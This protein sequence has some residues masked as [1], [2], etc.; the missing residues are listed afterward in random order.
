MWGSKNHVALSMKR[1]F[2]CLTR[3]P[4]HGEVLFYDDWFYQSEGVDLG[5]DVPWMLERLQVSRASVSSRDRD[6][7]TVELMSWT[8]SPGVSGSE[9]V[10]ISP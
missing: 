8:P 3:Y 1:D 6:M 4:S 2:E 5:V 7:T 9:R 10:S